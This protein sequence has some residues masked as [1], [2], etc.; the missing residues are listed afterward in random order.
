MHLLGGR[1]HKR[2]TGA[3]GQWSHGS[4]DR[5]DTSSQ[6]EEGKASRET[7]ETDIPSPKRRS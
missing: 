4:A 5:A 6:R 7:Q 2:P 1:A 3:H